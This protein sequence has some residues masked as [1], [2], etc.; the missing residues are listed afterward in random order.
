MIGKKGLLINS[1]IGKLKKVLMHRP[2]KE[3]EN[4]TPELMERLLFDDIPFLEM[5][6][7]EHDDFAN[8]LK[9]K[10]V[11]VLYL[12][13]LV[14]ESIKDLNIKNQFITEFVK[15][16]K[17]DSKNMR[18]ALE[19]YF[20]SFDDAG[21]MVDEMIQ[22][23]RSDTVTISKKDT[24]S[25]YTNDDDQFL[26]D[27]MPNLYFTRDP[28]S[29][30]ANGVAVSNMKSMVRRRE[31]IFT[32]YILKY[33]PDFK[34]EEISKWY[35][36]KDQFILEGGDIAVLSEEVVV[37]GISK[38]T[39]PEAI[40]VLAKRLLNDENGIKT[41]LV[42]EIPKGRQ[43]L[44]L[45]TVFTMIDKEAFLIDPDIEGALKIYSIQKDSKDNMIF[46]EEQLTLERILSKYLKLKYVEL[47]R[48]GGYRGIDASREQWSNAT[49]VLAI[50]PG[51]V[52]ANA[53]NHVTNDLLKRKGISVDIISSSELSRGH[54]GPR[55][56]VLPLVRE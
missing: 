7:K 40:D 31:S 48:C 10:G 14:V 20:L 4:L 36:P 45:D 30:I 33:H 8:L 37:V 41:I 3:I 38:R 47:I 53:R 32:S 24:L 51:E 26:I 50:G 42:F 52:V 43:F 29:T 56:M 44:H 39:E 17:T 34:N 19:E 22:G 54:G 1:E 35:E 15:G 28:F 5:A 25:D 18:K 27:P 13:D 21:E 12:K 23:V 16:T 9:S 2:G 6:R 11:E 49:N 46:T 55:C